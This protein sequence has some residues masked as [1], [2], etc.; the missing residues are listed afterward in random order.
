M[1]TLAAWVLLV[2]SILSSQPAAPSAIARIKD[3]ALHRSRVMEAVEYLS[4]V[5]G[6]R[7]TGSRGL[8]RAQEYGLEWLRASGA[9]AHLESWG[10]FGRGW[11]L[12]RASAV[13]TQ[14]SYATLIA[15]PSA[16]SPSTAGMVSGTPVLLEAQDVSALQRYRG[17]LRGRI[18]LMAP[19]R[20]LDPLFQT[21][22]G[23][24]LTDDELQT[25]V[26]APPPGPFRPP[27]IR[28]TQAAAFE[29]QK[30][31]FV[32]TE[33][34][35]VV[36]TP[37]SWDGGTVYV[38]SA[39][40]P[41]DPA[42]PPGQRAQPWDARV[43]NVPPQMVVSAEQY[44]RLVRLV[45]RGVAVSLA[46]QIT[47]RFTADRV[48]S[49]NVIGESPGTDLRDQI[50]MIG[51]C[52]DSWHAGTGATDN[53]AG[54]AVVL[55]VARIFHDLHLTPRRTIRF[56]LWSAEEQGGWGSRAYVAAHFGRRSAGGQVEKGPDYDRLDGY[57]NLDYGTGRIRGI[58][59]QGNV[60]AQ[61]VFHDWFAPLADIGAS[62]VTLRTIGATD[63]T[64]FDEIGLPGF[65][66]LRDYM[67]GGTRTAHTNMDVYDHVLP[68]DLRQSA[69]VAAA[70]V[71]EAAMSDEKLPGR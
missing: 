19:E 66:F 57:F 8:R 40:A 69:A 6:P 71:Y 26:S 58:Y 56:G 61:P 51:G 45:R 18:V 29:I 64:A 14:P 34:P 30:W 63:H 38:T 59:A 60:A 47:A 33:R 41:N 62:T 46:I 32:A 49:A 65:Q 68:D 7:L 37:S 25:L 27:A 67:E 5:V 36:L 54:A 11:E 9:D 35:G 55:E 70:V 3:E 31:R 22:T 44:N 21:Q 2:S 4:D 20:P 12:E 48:M 24:R 28:E 52:M 1:P 15:Y 13:M 16:W 53:A 39:V 50:V 42:T 10:P 23:H 43:V 17:R